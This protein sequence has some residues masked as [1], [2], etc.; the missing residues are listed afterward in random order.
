MTSG[1]IE[2]QYTP[3]NLRTAIID[4]LRAE[5]H[6]PDH[7]DPDA[8][9]PAEEFHTLGRAGSQALADAADIRAG[10]RVLDIGCGIGGPARFLA[11][12]FGCSVTG[13]DLSAEFVE[14]AR[15]LNERVGVTDLVDIHRADALRMPFDRASFDVVWTQHATMNVADKLAFYREVT[16]VL[17]PAGRLAFFDIVAGPNQPVHF[18]VPWADEPDRNFLEPADKVRAVVEASGFIV[19]HWADL[20]DAALEWFTA[21][22]ARPPAPR[23]LGL[24]LLVPDVQTKVVNLRRNLEEDRIRLLRCVAIRT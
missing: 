4:A 20:S 19:R 9:A 14:V 24:H 17:V 7:P 1:S 8:L 21:M 15:D 2:A 11:R 5:G 3:G 12:T 22:A 6:D 23:P 10:E 13:I 18:P 16:R